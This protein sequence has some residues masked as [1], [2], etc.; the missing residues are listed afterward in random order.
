MIFPPNFPLGL[1]GL[2]GGTTDKPTWKDIEDKATETVDRMKDYEAALVYK[3]LHAR[4]YRISTVDGVLSRARRDFS[5][6]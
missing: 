3:L 6:S 5:A 4:G 2:Y 1:Y